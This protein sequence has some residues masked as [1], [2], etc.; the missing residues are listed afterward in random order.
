[1]VDG[2]G[3]YH[4]FLQ[5]HCAICDLY[6]AQSREKAWIMHWNWLLGALFIAMAALLLQF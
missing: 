2:F 4:C 3:H 5:Q 6:A 1:M